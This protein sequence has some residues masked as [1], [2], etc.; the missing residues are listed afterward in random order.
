MSY[1]SDPVWNGVCALIVESRVED[2]DTPYILVNELHLFLYPGRLFLTESTGLIP[3][4]AKK[5]GYTEVRALH[6]CIGG[7]F[8]S[9]KS[10]CIRLAQ[11]LTLAMIGKETRQ[12]RSNESGAKFSFFYILSDTR[13]G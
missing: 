12:E 8:L 4:T 2:S 13:S 5:L 7:S 3:S 10:S 11:I 9:F 6:G 1:D